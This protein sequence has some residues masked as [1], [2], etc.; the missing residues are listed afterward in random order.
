MVATSIDF[1]VRTFIDVVCWGIMFLGNERDAGFDLEAVEPN[2]GGCMIDPLKDHC[3]WCG[4][5]L[6]GMPK[7]VRILGKDS[8]ICVTCNDDLHN[9]VNQSPVEVLD[10]FNL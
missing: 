7:K 8:V 6:K 5:S 9:Y 3:D 1:S 4:K 2:N 10:E